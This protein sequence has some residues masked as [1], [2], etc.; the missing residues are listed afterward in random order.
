MILALL[1]HRRPLV[2]CT[3][4]DSIPGLER[5]EKTGLAVF[6]DAIVRMGVEF[7]LPILDLRCVC[8]ERADYS[9]LSPIEPSERGGSKIVRAILRVVNGHDFSRAESVLYR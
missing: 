8:D 2:I 3:V 7:G 6:N 5:I 9:A 4:Y 1:A